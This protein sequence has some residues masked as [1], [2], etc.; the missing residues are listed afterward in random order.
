M[1]C[2]RQ[3]NVKRGCVEREKEPMPNTLMNVLRTGLLRLLGINR[4]PENPLRVGEE[5]AQGSTALGNYYN[6]YDVHSALLE[7][8]H[9][10]AQALME[11]EKHRLIC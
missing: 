2:K 10:K 7:A 6:P 1:V 3:E 5:T 8:E 9:L 11:W 4:G